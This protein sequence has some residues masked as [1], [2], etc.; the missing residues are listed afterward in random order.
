M[1]SEI[2]T[3][4]PP[5][6]AMLGLTFDDVLLLPAES[7]VV[8]G[9]ADTSTQLSRRVRLNVPL[10]SS[11]MDTVTESR[12]AIAMARAGGLGVL[13]RNLAPEQQAAQ[14]EVVKRSEAGMVTDPVTCS[15][16]DT[17]ADVDALCS[18][19]RISGLPVTDGDGKLV[20]IITNRDMRFEMD[21]ARPVREVMTLAPLITAKIGVSAEAALGL[22]RRNKLEK[23]PIV[24]GAG[25]LRGLITIKDFNKTEKYPLATKDPDGRLVVA[26]AV[27]VGEETAEQL[28]CQR[29]AAGVFPGRLHLGFATHNLQVAQEGD[30]R[31]LHELHRLLERVELVAIDGRLC[32]GE[33]L[34]GFGHG[35]S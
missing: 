27:G 13:H 17:L 4:L 32:R 9:Q 8:P 30:G 5:K 34:A 25:I 7:D 28:Q 24:D 1:T 15:P 11:P 20:G 23:L 19:F 29:V 10:V 3:G 21:H 35:Y 26:S 12:M 6:F 33:P 14:V 16:D 18:R 2:V 22:L 31:V